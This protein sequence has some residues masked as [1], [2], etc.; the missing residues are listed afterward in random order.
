MLEFGWR[1]KH[2]H[3][4]LGDFSKERLLRYFRLR[5]MNLRKRVIKWTTVLLAS[6]GALGRKVRTG[7]VINFFGNIN[8]TTFIIQAIIIIVVG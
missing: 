5:L 2:G 6:K 8:A 4:V 3:F 7:F 1:R